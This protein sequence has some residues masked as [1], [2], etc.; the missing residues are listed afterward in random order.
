M[1][2]L[3]RDL[4]DKQLV[5][6]NGRNIGRVDGLVLELRPNQPPRVAAMELG[7]LTLARRVHPPLERWLQALATWCG[8]ALA[9]IRLPLETFRDVGIDIELDLDADAD[10]R[11]LRAERWL[12]EHVIR[13]IPGGKT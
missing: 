3:V 11:L 6:R 10:P 4:L 8:H 12:S 7:P 9:P 5:D 2:N 13:R 1:M